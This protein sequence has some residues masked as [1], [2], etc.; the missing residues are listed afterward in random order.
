MLIWKI[1]AAKG[2][3]KSGVSQK[4][5]GGKANIFPVNNNLYLIDASGNL[6]CIDALLGN[7]KW[8]LNNLYTNGIVFQ[9]GPNEFIFTTT[10]NRIVIV[11]TKL[12]KV[13]REIELT[14]E[15]KNEIITDLMVV[16]DK[17]LLGFSDGWVYSIK[18]KQK[19]EKL[20][21]NGFSPII[22]LMKINGNCLITDYDGNFNLIRIPPK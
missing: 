10:K 6:F 12:G 5:S 22:S 20:F 7:P 21:R 3:W 19:V 14:D 8:N 11:S 1:P 4:K 9:S 16:G 15:T 2:G 17:I 13:S 18:E